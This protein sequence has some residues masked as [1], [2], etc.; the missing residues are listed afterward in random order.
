[1]KRIT[2]TIA[3]VILAL[4]ACKKETKQK[5]YWAAYSGSRL[6]DVWQHNKPSNDQIQK[7]KDTCSC[8]VNVEEHCFSCGQNVTDPGGNDVSCQ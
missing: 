2:I 8:S 1:M 4:I 7:I 6:I 5:C 3:I